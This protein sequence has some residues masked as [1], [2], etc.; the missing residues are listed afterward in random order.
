MHHE[1]GLNDEVKN[2]NLFQKST[3]KKNQILKEIG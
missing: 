3:K 1:L 2:N